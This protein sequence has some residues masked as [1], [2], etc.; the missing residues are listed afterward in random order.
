M[1]IAL[2][3]ITQLDGTGPL[4][5]DSLAKHSDPTS[6][7]TVR[8]ALVEKHTLKQHPRLGPLLSLTTLWT[9]HI[10]KYLKKLTL[11]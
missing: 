9:I 5:L 3:L 10:P 1:R 6:T 4:P 7:K 8:Q 2:R 11:Q